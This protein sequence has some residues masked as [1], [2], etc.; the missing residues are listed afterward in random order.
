MVERFWPKPDMDV[1][2]DGP[3]VRYSDYEALRAELDAVK[4]EAVEVVRPFA[5]DP[6]LDDRVSDDAIIDLDET[7][8][9][10]GLLRRARAFMEKHSND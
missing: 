8:I 2:P 5:E 4:R 6:A 10:V 3:F 9:T 1:A 7:N